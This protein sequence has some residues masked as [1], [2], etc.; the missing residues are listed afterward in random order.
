MD[1]TEDEQRKFMS[2]KK[3][4]LRRARTVRICDPPRDFRE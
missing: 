1:Q 4:A 2:L 3:Q